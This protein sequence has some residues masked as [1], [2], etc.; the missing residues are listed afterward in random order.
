MNQARQHGR[1]D[2]AV[3]SSLVP[4]A[5]GQAAIAPNQ[6]AIKQEVQELPFNNGGNPGSIVDNSFTQALEQGSHNRQS[7]VSMTN[8]GIDSFVAN[9]AGHGSNKDRTVQ[10]GIPF[11][12]SQL[13][14]ALP[15]ISTA[16]ASQVANIHVPDMSVQRGALTRAAIP[17]PQGI[18]KGIIDLNAFCPCT[19][20]G[21]DCSHPGG[22]YSFTNVLSCTKLI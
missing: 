7:G 14:F 12:R 13:R 9:I 10:G 20:E 2:Q 17:R 8:Q 16:R 1:L 5:L 6:T 11:T 3:S 4:M 21:H 19:L 15:G 18:L 22:D